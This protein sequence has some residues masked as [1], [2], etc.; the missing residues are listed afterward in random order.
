MIC[1]LVDRQILVLLKND[2]HFHVKTWKKQEE[3][4]FFLYLIF[5]SKSNLLQPTRSTMTLSSKDKELFG[6]QTFHFAVR[7]KSFQTSDE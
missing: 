6:N 1:I 3:V 5:F 7:N 4:A 2:S